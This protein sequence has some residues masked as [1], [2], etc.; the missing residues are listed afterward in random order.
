MA[1]GANYPNPFAASTTLPLELLQPAAV[2]VTVFDLNGK[3]VWER[4]F[5]HLPAGAQTFD[6]GAD[7]P[8]GPQ[9]Y[10]VQVVATTERGRYVAVLAHRADVTLPTDFAL[11]QA[12]LHNNASSWYFTPSNGC[13]LRSTTCSK[14][15][16]I[17]AGPWCTILCGVARCRYGAQTGEF[18]QPRQGA[19][20]QNAATGKSASLLIHALGGLVAGGFLVGWAVLA[21]ISSWAGCPSCCT[22]KGPFLLRCS[23]TLGT[24]RAQF[25]HCLLN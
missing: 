12:C 15:A 16:S 21:V 22:S 4:D 20:G 18:S 24:K 2:H 1:L 7:L 19:A 3:R 13:S 6:L 10:A 23:T 17:D 8:S 11:K 9:S 25:R 14:A 5:G